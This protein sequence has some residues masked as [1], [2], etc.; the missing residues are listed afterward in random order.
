MVALVRRPTFQWP[1]LLSYDHLLPVEN[2]PLQ[3]SCGID[4]F[5]IEKCTNLHDMYFPGQA[6]QISLARYSW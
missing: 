6:M 2:Y 3:A 5:H 1:L 4:V